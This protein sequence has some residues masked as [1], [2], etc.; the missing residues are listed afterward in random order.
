MVF[1]EGDSRMGDGQKG[2]LIKI[3]YTYP[4][5]MKLGKVIAQVEQ[6]QDIIKSRE[7]PFD[8]H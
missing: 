4:A 3:R 7:T 2:L 8:F 1:L 6:I 5:M